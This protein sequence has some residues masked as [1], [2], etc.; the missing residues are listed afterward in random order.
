MMKRRRFL[1]WAGAVA[2]LA[3][4][5]TP[6]FARG[7]YF[8]RAQLKYPGSWDTNPTAANRFLRTLSMRT[9]V[10]PA[11][12]RQ[13]LEIG[14]PRLYE[15][16]FLYVAG[17]GGFPTLGEEGVS[18]LR[19]YV[20][21]GGFILFDDSSARRDSGFARGVAELAARLLP[22]RPFAPLPADHAVFQAFY[23]LKS[24][25]GRK[26][27]RPFLQGVEVEDLTVMMLC[28]NDLGGAW[29]GDQ[30]GG[31]TYPCVPGGEKQREMSFRM[32][33]NIVLYALTGNYKKDQVH[34]PFIMKRRRKR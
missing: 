33:I 29:E 10:E 26:V 24:V 32:G 3:F 17:R 28:H 34:I 6:L 18:W 2:T 13:L 12:R 19:T 4:L 15:A 9:S 14:D 7:R 22:G 11:P 31:Y 23:L 27:V 1:K 5:P 25:P 20:E 8:T 16:P 21:N 30:L